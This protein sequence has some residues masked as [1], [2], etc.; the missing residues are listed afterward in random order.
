MRLPGSPRKRVLSVWDDGFVPDIRAY[1]PL[2]CE[3]CWRMSED[4]TDWVAHIVEDE[5]DPSLGPT[6]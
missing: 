4:G 2:Q 5:E 6:S 3:E 1:R